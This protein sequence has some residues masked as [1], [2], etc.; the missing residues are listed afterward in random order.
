MKST[1]YKTDARAIECLTLIRLCPL[2]FR[3]DC[4]NASLATLQSNPVIFPST[5]CRGHLGYLAPCPLLWMRSIIFS[6]QDLARWAYVQLSSH[7]ALQPG[8]FPPLSS[9]TAQPSVLMSDAVGSLPN[10][11]TKIK[12]HPRCDVGNITCM[13]YTS[14]V[15]VHVLSHV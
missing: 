10:P 11:L 4:V 8:H 15:C 1:L 13:V 2:H 6:P 9:L 14:C 5:D 7:S 3:I 12:S